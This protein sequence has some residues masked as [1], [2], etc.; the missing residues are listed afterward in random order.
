MSGIAEILLGQ[1]FRV[2]GSDIALSPVCERLKSLG[3]TIYIGHAAENVAANVSNVVYSSAI[4]QDN[5]ELLEARGRKIPV[6]RRADVLAELMRLKFGVAVA[7]SHG[8]T[9]TTSLCAAILE[10]AGLDPTVIIGGVV[11]SIGSGGKLGTGDFLVA[12]SDESDRSFL[13]LKPTV[14]V[15][16]NID[17]EHLGA[18]RS[19]DDLESSFEKFISSVPFYGVAVLCIDD[20]RVRSIAG[21]IEGRKITYGISP[22]AELRATDLEVEAGSTRFTVLRNKVEL[23][24]IGLPMPGKHLA[25]NSLAAIAVALEFDV[26]FSVIQDS[27]ARFNGVG[28]RLEMIG[29]AAGVLVIDDYGH[30]PTEIRATLQ[31]I[32]DSWPDRKLHVLFQPHRYSRTRDSFAEFLD[33]FRLADNLKMAP[34]YAAGEDPIEGISSEHLCKA[35]SHPSCEYVPELDLLEQAISPE[36]QSGDIVLCLGAGSIGTIAVKILRSLKKR[37]GTAERVIHG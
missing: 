21:K 19:L 32:K 14:A 29:E 4:S 2:S 1:G 36:I 34:I 13:S 27:L 12:E 22:D 23:G 28:R 35:L 33:A 10:N 8:K 9:T 11:K 17:V 37:N 26:S 25:L 20:P 18:Y 5:P 6:I 3:A 15:V 16:T 7:G 30:H 24:R 31:A